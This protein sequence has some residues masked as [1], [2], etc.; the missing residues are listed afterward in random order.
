MQRSIIRKRTMTV[1]GNGVIHP[2]DQL[3]IL[4]FSVKIILIIVLFIFQVTEMS[5]VK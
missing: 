5:E 1:C 4:G 2:R 3:A